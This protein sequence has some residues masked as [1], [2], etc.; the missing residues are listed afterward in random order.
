MQAVQEFVNLDFNNHKMP[1]TRHLGTHALLTP[2]QPRRQGRTTS[3]LL[4]HIFFLGIFV[5]KNAHFLWKAFRVA[6]CFLKSHPSSNTPSVHAGIYMVV[7]FSGR[8]SK[9]KSPEKK[10]L[11]FF[12]VN[13]NTCPLMISIEAQLIHQCS[14]I[15]FLWNGWQQKHVLNIFYKWELLLIEEIL[16]HL[17]YI[18]P[19]K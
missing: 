2:L 9:Q 6:G 18:K 12:W 17:G 14:R 15:R 4:N 1:Q 7:F 3:P 11:E 19:C 5:S 10:K 16:H 8:N 13:W